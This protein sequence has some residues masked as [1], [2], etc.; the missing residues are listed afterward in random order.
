MSFA[1]GVP[2]GSRVVT[3]GVSNPSVGGRY[4][5]LIDANPYSGAEY[6]ESPWQGLLS[7][8]G[9]RTGADA[10]KENMAVQA[11]EYN[12]AIL[13]KQYDEEYNDPR[14]QVARLRAAGVNPDLDGGASVSPGEAASLPQDPSTPMQSEGAEDRFRE[15]ANFAVSAFS[16][17]LGM[18]ETI[19]GI[20]GRKLQNTLMSIQGENDFNSFARSMS[21]M[22][23]PK[24]L[25]LKVFRILIGKLKHLRMQKLLQEASS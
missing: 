25:I 23:L 19:Q 8:F 13:Q 10:W 4:Q 20:Q 14:N 7:M 22:F 1:N 21:G 3:S 6:T 17:A 2:G 9:I 18:I 15:F 24:R 12:A 11:N 16:S 5:D